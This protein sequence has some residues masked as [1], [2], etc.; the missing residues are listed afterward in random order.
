[1]RSLAALVALAAGLAG[2]GFQA[3][4]YGADGQPITVGFLASASLQD[5]ASGAVSIPIGLNGTADELVSVRY[6]FT[7]GTATNGADYVGSDNTLTIPSGATEA[8]IPLTINMDGLEEQAETI[9]LELSDPVGAQLGT[10]QHTVT[11]SRDILPRV[12]FESGSSQSDE[13]TS[14]VLRVSLDVP[15]EIE[16]SVDYVITGTASAGI[17][18][19]L[20]AGKLTFAPGTGS[21]DLPVPVT[22]DTLDEFDENFLVTLTSS[23]NVVVGT[24]ASHDHLITDNDLEPTVSFA[25][26]TQSRQENGL[27]VTLTVKLSAASGKPIKV[28]VSPGPAAMTDAATAGQDY[29]FTPDRKSVV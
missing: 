21:K 22:D 2:C 5:E 20:T 16:V 26:A 10:S 11:I 17:D 8:K 6:R 12:K 19:N 4:N 14:P 25:S 13:A 15:S 9:K 24:V 29:L 18:Y 23:T 7:G 1:M 27:V 3:P 28:D